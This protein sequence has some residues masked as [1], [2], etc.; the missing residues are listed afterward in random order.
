VS[1]TYG[2]GVGLLID[3]IATILLLASGIYIV[4]T[5]TRIRTTKAKKKPNC[6]KK[7][8]VLG[9]DPTDFITCKFRYTTDIVVND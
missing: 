3:L 7:F 2:F 5:A 8:R 1:S 4:A 9:S 6:L